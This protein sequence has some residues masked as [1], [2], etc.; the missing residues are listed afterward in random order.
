MRLKDFYQWR[1]GKAAKVPV[2]IAG[3]EGE[4]FLPGHEYSA[5]LGDFLREYIKHLNTPWWGRGVDW[6]YVEQK[7]R[8][9]LNNVR[10]H[11]ESVK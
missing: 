2:N 1:T 11:W 3:L 6:K 7:M 9:Q 10:F 4:H 5:P 8:D